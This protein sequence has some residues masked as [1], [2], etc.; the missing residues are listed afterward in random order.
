M[1]ES[2]KLCDNL[3]YISRNKFNIIYLIECVKVM[4]FVE[5]ER[6][7]MRGKIM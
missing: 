5:K 2:N 7:K 3:I 1:F 6:V 4:E